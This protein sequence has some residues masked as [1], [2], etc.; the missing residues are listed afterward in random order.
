MTGETA[1]SNSPAE[2][3]S[4]P[5]V[6]EGRGSL[7]GFAAQKKDVID[8]SLGVSGAVLL[9]GF[10]VP[11]AAAF[12]AVIEAYG[13]P[14]FTYAESLS[15]AVRVNVTARVF[16]AN[17]APPETEIF[18][19]HEMAQTPKYPSK[20]G[21]Y[22]EIAPREGGATPL[23]RSDLLFAELQRREPDLA[24][25][26]EGRGVRYRSTMPAEDDAASGQGRG[27]RSM[28]CANTRAEAE[29]RLKGLGYSYEWRA[30]D[31]LTALT[32]VLSAVRDIGGGRKAFFNQLI[33]AFCGWSDSRNDAERTVVF[34]DGEAITAGHMEC[35]IAL[36]EELVYDHVWQAGDVVLLDNFRVMHGRRPFSGK[37]RVLASLIG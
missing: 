28:L 23:C 3:L 19:H 14:G 36:S 31:S 32:P 4:Q 22:C 37:R 6:I 34:G 9:R 13:E 33:A 15:N 21:F 1:A 26:F 25:Q 10:D 30:D 17:E 2:A 29:A 8:H 16:T 18:M 27:W 5:G 12:D 24:A 20:L 35:P 11:N 7:A